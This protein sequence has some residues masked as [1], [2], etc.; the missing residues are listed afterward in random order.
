M[1]C[2]SLDL[3]HDYSN[4][5]SPHL[6]RESIPETNRFHCQETFPGFSLKFLLLNFTPLLD[7]KSLIFTFKNDL[8]LMMLTSFNYL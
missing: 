1:C 4:G 5:T 2:P 6:S 7:Y 8:A 3:V